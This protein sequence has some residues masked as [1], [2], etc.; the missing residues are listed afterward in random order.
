MTH[1]VDVARRWVVLGTSLFDDTVEGLS[2]A[3]L[4][5]PSNLPDWS[6][7]YVVAHVA[8]NADALVNLSTWALT[9]VETPMYP[10][11]AARAAGIEASAA[12]EPDHLRADL[13]AS[14]ER[15]DA[16]LDAV[17]EADRW[18]ARVT[19]ARGRD[20]AAGE[21]PW[22]RVR[23]VWLHALD[24]GEGPDFPIAADIPADLV[25]ALAVDVLGS[26]CA[27]AGCPTATVVA[28]DR[29]ADAGTWQL[30]P[31]RADSGRAPQTT[32]TGTAADLVV[33]LTGRS[34]GEA[35]LVSDGRLPVLP[36]WL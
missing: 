20:I 28:V 33:W 16:A 27:T 12:V 23:E 17:A 19:T 9:G 4:Q 1:D 6:R 7:A 2:D 5:A 26:L 36:A 14:G 25:D 22:M 13:T 29:P 18:A 8:R 3:D 10:D 34:R 32:V 11:A 30:G 31:G 15:L 24:L 21:L 35:L